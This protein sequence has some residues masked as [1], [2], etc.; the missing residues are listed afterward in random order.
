MAISKRIAADHHGPLV[1]PPS[2]AQLAGQLKGA[3]LDDALNAAIVD[4]IKLQQDAWISVVTDGEL[5][6][7][8]GAEDIYPVSEARF[9]TGQ[10]DGLIK[11]RETR[12]KGNGSALA[13][14]AGELQAL[15]DQG[16]RYVEL[17]G[18][19]YGSL[20]HRKSR[21]AIP[22]A[23]AQLDKKIE[24]DRKLLSGLKKDPSARIGICFHDIKGPAGPAFGVD[25]DAA[26]TEK[27]LNSLPVD[28]FLF[29][30]GSGEKTDFSYL[31]F[32]PDAPQA[33]LCLI[34]NRAQAWPD[35]DAIVAQIDEAAKVIDTDRF[36]VSF[37]HG[38]APLPGQDPQQAWDYQSRM[39][40]LLLDT[41]TRAW[42]MDF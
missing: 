31:K 20:L 26:A 9:L 5:R 4:L 39:L 17:D 42:A 10:T 13:A 25:F 24:Y 22:D 3:A 30:G 12:P 21:E 33:V 19:D 7:P 15:L 38:F 23:D 37:R 11:V 27:V 35:P 16:V 34:D 18:A 36:A 6:R 32:L 41:S 8:A 40:D 29:D 28:R 1:P 14:K 2:F